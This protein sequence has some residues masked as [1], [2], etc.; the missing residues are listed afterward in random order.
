MKRILV[1]GGA[2]FIGRHL[3]RHLRDHGHEVHATSRQTRREPED[4]TLTWHRWDG[5]IEEFAAVLRT[6]RPHVVVHAAARATP[7]R[8]LEEMSLQLEGTVMPSLNVA[9][10][11]TPD[12]ELTLFLG[13]CEEYGNGPAPADE[14]QALAAMSPYGWAKIS[15]YHGTRLIAESRGVNW[16]WLRPYLAFGPGQLGER[17]VP[18]VIRK[19]LDS[20]AVLLTAGNQ[21]RD[22]VYVADMCRMIRRIVENAS[23][24]VGQVFNLCSGQPRSIRD[25]AAM[26][27]GII[28]R[29]EIH[30]GELPYR[31]NEAMLF[32]GSP[33]KFES[34]FGQIEPT[35]FEAALSETIAW[36]VDQRREAAIE[37]GGQ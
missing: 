17:L 34:A 11:V 2:G 12:I 22:F 35:S 3:C 31:A 15:A 6:S 7:R 33:S 16:C 37:E 21:T 28:G 26:I 23:R 4:P 36:H 25:V 9:T 20:D 5:G 8:D 32:Y 13:S 19:C 18:T 14:S 29:G 30:L 1:T 27:R 24:A 10:A